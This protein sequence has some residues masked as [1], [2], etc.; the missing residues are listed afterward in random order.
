MVSVRPSDHVLRRAIQ[1]Y[2]QSN[3]DESWSTFD[4]ERA[5]WDDVFDEVKRVEA[6]YRDKAASNTVRRLF[7]RQAP[8]LVPNVIPL[9]EALP[10]DYGLGL[11][12]GSLMVVLKVG[13]SCGFET[14]PGATPSPLLSLTFPDADSGI[15]GC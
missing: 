1:D 2:I 15:I 11:L 13:R 3:P 8:A 14:F 10:D 5:S 6:V 9:L 7:R 12:K 4:P